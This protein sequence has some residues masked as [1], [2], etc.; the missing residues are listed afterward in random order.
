MI[1]VILIGLLGGLITG[2]SPCIVPV[3]P[4]I[5]MSGSAGARRPLLVVAG[6]VLSFSVSAL[7]G[8]LL[9]RLLSLPANVIRV[10]GLVMLALIGLG[11][12]FPAVESVLERPFARIPQ[13]AISTSRGGFGLG[14]VLGLVFVP[15]AGPVL[16]AI[17]VAGATGSIGPPAVA[18][19]IAFGIGVAV[20]LAV[21]ALA[22]RGGQGPTRSSCGRWRG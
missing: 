14:L 7:L 17:V 11:L 10:T 21:F 5:F 20:P 8:S 9:L 16:A 4:V 2:I 1:S 18:L 19:T 3:L 13:R 15:C 6:L 22:G 12:I